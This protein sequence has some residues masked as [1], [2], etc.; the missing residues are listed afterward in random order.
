MKKNLILGLGN[1]ILCDDAIG[2]FVI[3]RAQEL[4]TDLEKHVDFKENHSGGFDLL[5]DI[6]GYNRLLVVDSIVTGKSKPGTC[7]S[8][9]LKDFEHLL[10]LNPVNSHSLNLPTTIRTGQKCGYTMPEELIILGIESADV[11]TLSEQLTANVKACVD[12]VVERIRQEILLWIELDST[13]H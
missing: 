12:N 2:L 1:S 3:R 13:V 5:Y 11:T 9:T 10:Q 4:L 7:F 8:F 6:N